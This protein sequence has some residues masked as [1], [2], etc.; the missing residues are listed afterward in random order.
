MHS[1]SNQYAIAPVWS[2]SWKNLFVNFRV[3]DCQIE[4]APYTL[5]VG[6]DNSLSGGEATCPN[7]SNRE[8]PEKP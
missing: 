8:R 5:T 4:R 3:P 1:G 7:L 2:R 6:E